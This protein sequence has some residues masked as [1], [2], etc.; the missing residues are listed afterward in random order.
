MSNKLFYPHF[1][2]NFVQISKHISLKL[3]DG[4]TKIYINN[5]L[6]RQC[7]AL[8]VNI[9]LARLEK[10]DDLTSID[11]LE[12]ETPNPKYTQ[13]NLSPKEEFWGHCSNIQAWIESDYDTRILHHS[14][15]FPLLR[16]LNNL[17][18][19]KAKRVFKDELVFRFINGSKQVK[20]F[21]LEEG[22]LCNFNF[23]EREVINKGLDELYT[24]SYFAKT[25]FSEDEIPLL[26]DNE[27][28]NGIQEIIRPKSFSKSFSRKYSHLKPIYNITEIKELKTLTD[29]TSLALIQNYI[30]EIKGIDG[31]TY[32]RELALNMN[33]IREIKNL[34]KLK[35]LRDLSLSGNIISEIKNLENLIELEFLNLSDNQITKIEGLECLKR[36]KVLNLWNNK[37][38]DIEG[39]EN[40][41]D[42]RK[43]SLG[44]NNISEIQGLEN[45][46]NLRVLVLNSNKISDI[47]GL[48][49]L[50]RLKKITFYN[51]D[52]SEILDFPNLPYLQELSL[53]MNPIN[54]EDIKDLQKNFGSKT[55]VYF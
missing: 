23:E 48:E 16:E 52:I 5:K 53:R 26:F 34:G 9:P 21:L 17:G 50:T 19:F 12:Q 31:F 14:L 22:F 39:L 55:R 13:S 10:Y 35:K 6:F 46:K 32:L 44:G 15:S 36:L 18:D 49:K 8:I 27:E 11:D 43:L 42:L 3:E 25:F 7:K 33:E 40:L 2:E 45:L 29:I 30:A 37:I 1:E 38:K 4:R 20:L 28:L 24:T 47:K 51:N 41:T 54:R